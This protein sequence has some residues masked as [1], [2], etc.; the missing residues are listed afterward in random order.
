MNEDFEM[1]ASALRLMQ[2]FTDYVIRE[3]MTEY[4]Y[5]LMK[6]TPRTDLDPGDIPG[7][8]RAIIQAADR[9]HVLVVVSSERAFQVACALNATTEGNH[10][11]ICFRNKW[12]AQAFL[13]EIRYEDSILV[14]S[15]EKEYYLKKPLFREDVYCDAEG[16]ILVKGTEA[17]EGP[18]VACDTL[19]KK[20]D[21]SKWGFILHNEKVFNKDNFLGTLSDMTTDLG[22]RFLLLLD[23]YTQ[24]SNMEKDVCPAVGNILAFDGGHALVLDWTNGT[25]RYTNWNDFCFTVLFGTELRN[26]KDIMGTMLGS[27]CS[28]DTLPDCFLGHLERA[29]LLGR[30]YSAQSW[31]AALLHGASV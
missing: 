5:P 3:G 2:L 19:Y 28:S 29:F 17:S 4:P 30:D 18:Q 25:G 26:C 20:R 6:D 31:G 10:M 21:S 24:W 14:D 23:I 11:A 15:N 13:E 9:G 12:D 22:Q 27:I 7:L 1:N 8:T 16:R